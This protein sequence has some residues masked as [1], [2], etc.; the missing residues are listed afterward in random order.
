[1]DEVYELRVAALPKYLADLEKANPGSRCVFEADA[2]GRLK[3][4]FIMLHSVVEFTRLVGR[5][6]SGSDMGH[7]QHHYHDGVMATGNF[8]TGNGEEYQVWAAYFAQTESADSW[9]Y[10]ADNI[11]V[12]SHLAHPL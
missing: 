12:G 11:K 8:K 5:P 6:V 7:L 9:G 10:I 2:D 1:M 4:F 3:R